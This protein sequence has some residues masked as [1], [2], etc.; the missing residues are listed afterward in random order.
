MS[1][2]WRQT[3]RWERS[4][5]EMGIRTFEIFVGVN[6][7]LGISFF[8]VG[9]NGKL[10]TE[11]T[12]EPGPRQ[13]RACEHLLVTMVKQEPQI[14]ET[15]WSLRGFPTWLVPSPDMGDVLITIGLESWNGRNSTNHPCFFGTAAMFDKERVELR[16]FTFSFDELSPFSMQTLFRNSLSDPIRLDCYC[17]LRKREKTTTSKQGASR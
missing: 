6:R 12:I 2:D 10:P 4:N 16:K 14:P 15:L 1:P 3:Q 9:V 17:I 7:G 13:N 8:D 11:A 5:A